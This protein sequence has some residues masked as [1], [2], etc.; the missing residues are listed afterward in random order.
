[1][2]PRASH[3]S[4]K[5]SWTLVLQDIGRWVPSRAVQPRYWER[6][7]TRFAPVIQEIHGRLSAEGQGDNWVAFIGH[8]LEGAEVFAFVH[9]T[10]PGGAHEL[11]ECVRWC[12]T[13]LLGPGQTLLVKEEK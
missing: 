12:V 10:P 13:D 8:D 9:H 4:P 3:S 6:P 5:D 2:G 7:V 11:I 1:M